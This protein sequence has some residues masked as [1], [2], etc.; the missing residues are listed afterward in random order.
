MSG[1][2]RQRL[3]EKQL[4][5]EIEELRGDLG[6]T[7]EA[8]ARKADVPARVK[9]RGAELTER[10]VDRGVELH[11]QAVARGDALSA[12]AI[13]WCNGVRARASER[14][15]EVRD[16]AVSATE[17]A[18]GALSQTPPNRWA[19]LACAGLALAVVLV[20]VRRVRVS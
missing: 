1:S 15:S 19:T 17:R 7:V 13:E 5:A 9:E 8:L 4:K 12:R 14:G 2:D 18:R 20:L 6:E 10:A 16:Q 3:Q 11:Q